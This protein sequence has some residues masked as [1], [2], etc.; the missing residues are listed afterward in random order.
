MASAAPAGHSAPIPTPSRAR[1]RNRKAKLGEKPAI[2]LQTEYHRI[3]TISGALRPQRS[4][5]QPAAV[6]PS[7]RSHSVTANTAVTAVSGT[8]NS[9][10]IGTM[11]SRKTVKSNASSVHPSQAAA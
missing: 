4:A 11:I 1:K 9:W 10:L 8:P 3:E 7:R 2:R 5:I 6:A